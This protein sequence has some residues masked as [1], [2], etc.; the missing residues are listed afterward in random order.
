MLTTKMIPVQVMEAFWD[1]AM[2]ASLISLFVL[3]RYRVAV[4]TGMQAAG[5]TV[6]PLPSIPLL[7]AAGLATGND[8]LRWERR[9]R[10]RIVLTL[11][12]ATG[13]PA[14]P[15][16]TQ[17]LMLS[18]AT[19]T[20]ATVSA[21][22]SG[23]MLA[24]VPMVAAYLALS[25][26]RG[27]ILAAAWVT[28]SGAMATALTILQRLFEG[29]TLKLGTLSVIKSV[30]LLS[31]IQTWQPLLLALAIGA[32]RVRGVAPIAFS[33][34]LV[35]G[36][37][38]QLNLR[39]FQELMNTQTGSDFYEKAGAFLG[40]FTP[41]S[42]FLALAPLI[43]W[44]SWRRLRSLAHQYEAKAFSDLQLLARTW[45]L[46]FC[47]CF[48]I[49]LA[50]AHPEHLGKTLAGCSIA[51]FAFPFLNRRFLGWAQSRRDRPQSRTLLL[52]RV[53]G[54][55][56]RTE[57]LFDGIG[58]R[59]RFFGPV[60]MIAAPDVV[61]RTVDAD[62]FLRFVSGHLTD[63][64]ITDGNDLD[65]RLATLDAAPDPDG[66]YRTNAFCCHDD[67]WRATVA[68]LIDRADVVLMDLRGLD[69]T[70]GG[71]AFE[72]EQLA[73]RMP[74][75]RIVLVV[76][77]TTDCTLIARAMKE[78]IPTLVSMDKQTDAAADGLFQAIVRA[79][80]F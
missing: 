34:L 58:A 63:S 16:A 6:L 40:I 42:I 19:V 49:D 11:L 66:R 20:P 29:G 72:L 24:A 15:L 23:L 13:I 59:W 79:A 39:L 76:D 3:W 44:F 5:N 53:F 31:V 71:C 47:L 68:T 52:L 74:A 36:L 8:P 46:M 9:M 54:H 14:F 2:I 41:H 30:P 18:G 38:A 4:L 64:F 60:N 45:W 70:R 75:E 67:T 25:V 50:N 80:K 69:A 73:M 27:L 12:G 51:Y 21:V 48:G 22:A 61:S 32:A 1:T 35:F 55:T 17:Y 65:T 43:G 37:A 33:G 77:D 28:A 10:R 78:T 57:Q 56:K 7:R 26:R 62:D